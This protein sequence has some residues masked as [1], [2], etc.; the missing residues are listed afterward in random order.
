M[1]LLADNI[2][3]LGL[4]DA[5]IGCSPRSSLHRPLLVGRL[6]M[7]AALQTPVPMHTCCHDFV[8][9]ILFS[10][11]PQAHSLSLLFNSAFSCSNL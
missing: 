4:C 6:L 10:H 9:N 8:I 3:S 5:T 2:S 1:L 11:F 7:A